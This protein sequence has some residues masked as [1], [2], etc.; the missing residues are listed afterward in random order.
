MIEMSNIFAI[1]GAKWHDY[2]TKIYNNLV[3]M[4]AKWHMPI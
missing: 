4:V 1:V 2:L 3:D